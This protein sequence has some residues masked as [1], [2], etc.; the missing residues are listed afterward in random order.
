MS[1][2]S[3]DPAWPA[4]KAKGDFERDLSERYGTDHRPETNA[5]D[6]SGAS[7]VGQDLSSGCEFLEAH[8]RS[9]H[10]E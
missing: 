6:P 10:R 8:P 1:A 9:N 3:T 2:P 4:S 5:T 7:D